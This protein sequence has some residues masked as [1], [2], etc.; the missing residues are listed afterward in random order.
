MTALHAIHDVME[1]TMDEV[2]TEE[3]SY[4]RGIGCTEETAAQQFMQTKRFWG[5]EDGRVC[6]HGYQSFWEG[7][8][9]AEQV[10]KI[11]VPLAKEVWGD[12]FE[13]AVATHCNT[14]QDHNHFIISSVS[15]MVVNSI[16]PERATD[17]CG[18]YPTD[19]AMRQ[20]SP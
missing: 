3:W 13:V 9:T 19:C 5:K 1:Y 6:F 4:V 18:K 17:V 15:W 14:N 16:T 7:E 20:N 2:K 10:H 11:G 12:R 8:V